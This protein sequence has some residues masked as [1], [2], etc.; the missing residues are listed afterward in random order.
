M[1]KGPAIRPRPARW[2]DGSGESESAMDESKGETWRFTARPGT[3]D[4]VYLVVDSA[5]A[6]SRWIEMQPDAKQAGLWTAVAEVAPGRTRLRYFTAEDGAYLNCGT[7][8]LYAE[9]V[10]E[11]CPAVQIEDLGIAAVG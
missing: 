11:R 4:R 6:P 10:S 2:R 1:K 9:R 8:G 3:A 5:T 7:A